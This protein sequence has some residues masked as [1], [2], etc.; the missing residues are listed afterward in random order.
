MPRIISFD[1]CTRDNRVLHAGTGRATY[2]DSVCSVTPPTPFFLSA[3]ASLMSIRL[4]WAA[5]RRLACLQ[6]RACCLQ[7]FLICGRENN[8]M[9]LCF[10]L[11]FLLLTPTFRSDALVSTGVALLINN[12]TGPGVPGMPPVVVHLCMLLCCARALSSDSSML[13][14]LRV[15]GPPAPDWDLPGLAIFVVVSRRFSNAHTPGVPRFAGL[16]NMFAEAGWLTPTV[17][18]LLVWS[19]SSLS[20]TMYVQ[21][22]SGQNHVQCLTGIARL[23]ARARCVRQKREGR[24]R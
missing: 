14:D 19:M 9:I 15:S 5:E 24:G 18:F 8:C 13:I 16:P 23:P 10:F 11:Y 4:K 17:I 6:V 7:S 2:A 21:I 1:P 20:T 3:K 12:I 22:V